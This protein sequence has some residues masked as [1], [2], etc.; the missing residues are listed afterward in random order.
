MIRDEKKAL[1]SPIEVNQLM[2]TLPT[3]YVENA[4]SIKNDELH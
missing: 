2:L 3:H 4:K 1:G